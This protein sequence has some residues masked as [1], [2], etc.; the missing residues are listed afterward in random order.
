[1]TNWCLTCDFWNSKLQGTPSRKKRKGTNDVRCRCS[2]P[3][4]K[5]ATEGNVTIITTKH[6][7]FYR[8]INE[9]PISEQPKTIH[10]ATRS[11]K[12]D[13]PTKSNRNS[14]VKIYLHLTIMRWL[15][16]K[17]MKW[18]IVINVIVVWAC[19][20]LLIFLLWF[21]LHHLL[22]FLHLLMFLLLLILYFLFLLLLIFLLLLDLLHM[23]EWKEMSVVRQNRRWTVMTRY[24]LFSRQKR[25]MF[26]SLT[27]KRIISL[28]ISFAPMISLIAASRILS[29]AW[30][31]VFKETSTHIYS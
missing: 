5:T 6:N 11:M 22:W 21:L 19:L 16:I 17:W 28:D 18:V 29:L 4:R 20:L 12:D 31:G 27:S 24:L 2:K 14:S 7:I 3:F 13:F 15:L 26:S 1:M 8:C 25:C 10:P 9:E 23:T 30:C